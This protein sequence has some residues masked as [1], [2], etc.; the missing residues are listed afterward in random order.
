MINTL[1]MRI[2]EQDFELKVNMTMK[3]GRIYRQHFGRDL[4]G[5]MTDVYKKANPSIYD[6]VDMSEVDVTNKSDEEV[7]KEVM[8]KA[9]PLYKQAKADTVFDYEYTERAS[10]IIWAFVK[11]A[12]P[13]A[14]GFEDWL[15]GYDFVLPVKDIVTALYDMWNKTAQPTIEIKN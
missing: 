7:Y 13:E 8:K 4:V 10:Q 5:D 15:D 14:P 12:D 1:K 9:W 11:N 6:L 2:N 3:A